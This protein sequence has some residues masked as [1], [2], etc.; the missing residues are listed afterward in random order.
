MHDMKFYSPRP[1]HQHPIISLAE[2]VPQ[3][4]ACLCLQDD[5]VDR[6]KP[7]DRVSIVGVYKPLAGGKATG[8]TSGLFK[9]RAQYQNFLLIITIL[10]VLR[11]DGAK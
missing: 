3:H 4:S 10:P 1:T 11:G 7:G 5:L 8:Q 6:V 2:S 9:V